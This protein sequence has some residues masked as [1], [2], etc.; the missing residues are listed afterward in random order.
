MVQ[1][2]HPE[3]F[4][5]IYEDWKANKT[6]IGKDCVDTLKK[7]AQPMNDVFLSCYFDNKMRECHEIFTE[8][9]TDEGVCYTFNIAN[10]DQ[11]FNK[12]S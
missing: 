9:I 2:C 8:T 5:L 10:S 11:I 6:L 1:I 4:L 3:I 7:L 12:K